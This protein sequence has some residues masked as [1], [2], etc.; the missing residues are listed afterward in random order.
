MTTVAV[1]YGSLS[2]ASQR[3]FV[4]HDKRFETVI[5]DAPRLERVAVVDAHEGPVYVEH[6]DAL[7]FTT[8]P[9]SVNRPATGDLEVAIKRLQLD[10]DRFPIPS[11]RIP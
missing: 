11:S 3:P 8:L 7:Y 6:E 1:L 2:A 10:G 4:S 9:V 5:G